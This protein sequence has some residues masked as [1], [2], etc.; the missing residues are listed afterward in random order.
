MKN[1]AFLV[2]ANKTII[3]EEV[4]K[5]LEAN[6]FCSYWIT[7]SQNWHNWL[8]NKGI[9]RDRILNLPE[10]LSGLSR[11]ELSNNEFQRIS[12]IENDANV[13]FRDLYFM[14][15]VLREKNYHYALRYM[16]KCFDEISLFLKERQIDICFSEQTWNFEIITTIACNIA[17]INSYYV[18][19]VK[20]PDGIGVG[21]FT[22]FNSYLM[23]ELPKNLEPD[24]TD[25]EF[26]SK[27]L[28]EY[29]KNKQGTSYL[30]SYFSMPGI[31]LNWVRKFFKHFKFLMF[32]KFDLTRRPL[33]SLIRFRLK[34]I[35]NYLMISIVNPFNEIEDIESKCYI[36]IA[37]HK[38]PDS[39]VDVAAS[40]F[41]NQFEAIKTLVSKIPLSYEIIIKDHSHS[42]G[43]NSLAQYRYLQSNP[44]VILAKPRS[45]TF[46]LIENAQLV[47]SLGGTVSLEAAIMG[48]RSLTA[49]KTFFSDVTMRDSANPYHLSTLELSKI[50]NE[51][52]PIDKKLIKYLASVRANS[53]LGMVFDPTHDSIYSS[54]EN[55]NNIY[56]GFKSFMLND[57]DG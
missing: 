1:I 43:L 13:S 9:P 14:D 51:E 22:F 36:L 15:R 45:D 38:Q 18:N 11:N 35:F 10:K 30:K 16:L 55:I 48:R 26:A 29:R 27:F 5:K 17:G 39:A 12:Y 56:L 2:S 28:D 53:Y 23:S 50:L 46:K 25:F 7:P 21:R 49:V 31:K 8:L 47:Y 40:A 41:L 24:K 57:S 52:P 33:I 54:D 34:Q 42:L 37:L 20:V 19:T 32:D 44:R 6:D 3:F 4:A